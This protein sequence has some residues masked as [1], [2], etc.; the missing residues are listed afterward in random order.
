[1]AAH[2]ARLAHTITGILLCHALSLF[3]GPLARGG[4]KALIAKLEC[5]DRVNGVAYSPDGQFL[6]VRL[7]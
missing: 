6:A 3:A 2:R 5:P 7:E 4:S 1:M